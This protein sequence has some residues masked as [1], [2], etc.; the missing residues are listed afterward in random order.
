MCNGAVIED[1]ATPALAELAHLKPTNLTGKLILGVGCPPFGCTSGHNKVTQLNV[2]SS[3]ISIERMVKMT[4]VGGE[5]C[6][7]EG[8]YLAWSEAKW[9]MK[10]EARL[11]TVE[12]EE[13]CGKVRSVNAYVAPF[14]QMESCMHHCQKVRNRAPSVVT[15]GQ[16]QA[17]REFAAT[18]LYDAGHS[19]ELW[20]SV[21]DMEEEG[22]WRDFYTG[23][24]MLHTPPFTGT[25]PNGREVENCALQVDGE[26]WVDWQCT[27]SWKLT[28]GC[29]CSRQVRPELRLRGVCTKSFLDTLFIPRNNLT[30]A[31]ELNFVGG[32]DTVIQYDR[33]ALVW[34]AA[35]SLGVTAVSSSPLVSYVLGK[36]TWRVEG[37]APACFSGE[38]YT[39]QLKLTGCSEEEFTCD[40]GQCVRMEERCD[41]VS[42]CRD[43]SDEIDCQLLL[44]ENNYNQK[45]PPISTV[46]RDN[47]TIVPVPIHVS[48]NLMKIV[49]IKEVDHMITLQ[50]EIIVKWH[51]VR[52]VY[53]N[54]KYKTSLN[55]LSD[56]DMSELWLPYA[57]FDN[58]DNK[59][60]VKLDERVKTTMVV[61]REGE[62]T[63]SGFEVLDEI[64]I[65][66]GDENP[67][68]L[69]QTHSKEFQCRYE[70]NSYPFDTQVCSIR[71]VASQLDVDMIRFIPDKVVMKER[72]KLTMYIVTKWDL[73]ADGSGGVKYIVVLK[74]RFLSEL[75]GTYLPTILLLGISFATVFFKAEYFEAALTV[76]LTNMLVL[77]TIFISVMQTLPK[78]AYVKHIDIWLIFCQL[79]P[80]AEVLLITAAE[81]LRKPDAAGRMTFN[82]HG[83]TRTIQAFNKVH[84]GLT[85]GSINSVLHICHVFS[86]VH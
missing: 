48:I 78:T 56:K 57:I 58:T 67:I 17:V 66:R 68:T 85:E 52:T 21:T 61:S 54:L 34:R 9:D 35:G 59:E 12:R 7:E 11:E 86:S 4:T 23:E 49:S 28:S 74:R 45:V 38:P 42:Q 13:V 1:N 36:H 26:Q 65:F 81:Y 5:E 83:H 6:G 2:F 41:Q 47:F 31:T 16:W 14:D 3:A 77:T 33:R 39:A 32:R 79:I 29:L 25:G 73:V 30:D 71:I 37:D 10:G 19:V 22:V 18:K 72:L 55:A 44:L 15:E 24:A 62:V 69:R 60:A 84:Y 51:E 50:F 63:R 82:H 43:R 20:M 40:D 8:D 70:L 75:L 53:Q 46:S 64:E 76:N 27:S 80:F